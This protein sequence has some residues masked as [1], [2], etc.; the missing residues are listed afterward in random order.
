MSDIK[1]DSRERV[2]SEMI[3]VTRRELLRSLHVLPPSHRL[4]HL[5]EVKFSTLKATRVARVDKVNALAADDDVLECAVAYDIFALLKV[6][7]L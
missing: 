7:K 3:R 2:H 6:I 5:C 4:Q 1:S